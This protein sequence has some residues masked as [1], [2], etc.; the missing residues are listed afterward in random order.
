MKAKIVFGGENKI[1][2]KDEVLAAE[3]HKKFRNNKK[4]LKIKVFNKDDIWSADLIETVNSKNNDNNRYILTI[5]DLYTR[6][7]WAIPLKN[8]TSISIK[9]AFETLFENT[10]DRIPK[11]LYVDMGKEFYNKIFQDFLKENEIEIYSTFNQ[12][13]ERTQGPSHNP[14][15]E[16][17][18]RTLKSLMYKKFTENGNRIWINIL[19]ELIDFYNNKIHR[20]IGVS[21]TEA[22]NFPEKI[23]EKVNQNNDENK[24]LIEK[25]K[26]NIGDRV[27]IYKWKNKFEKGVTHSWTKE[28]FIIKKIYNTTPFTNKLYNLNEEEILGRFYSRK[29]QHTQF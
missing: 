8:K 24:D 25:Q 3:L 14:V 4:Y 11:K 2:N 21:P 9:E 22:S 13:D 5:I 27:R 18:N 28:I 16:R 26:F 6:F 23:R 29:L 12:P 17:F 7:A 1:E 15:I 20:T 10:P 19:P